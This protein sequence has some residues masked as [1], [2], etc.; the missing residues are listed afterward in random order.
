V[1]K[2]TRRHHHSKHQYSWQIN[3]INREE[4]SNEIASKKVAAHTLSTLTKRNWKNTTR[5]AGRRNG[6]SVFRFLQAEPKTPFIHY[7]DSSD[8]ITGFTGEGIA[9]I[10]LTDAILKNKVDEADAWDQEAQGEEED[11]IAFSLKI[12]EDEEEEETEEEKKE[13]HKRF[14]SMRK[15][16]YNMKAALQKKEEDDE[17][18]KE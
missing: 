11:G 15:G 18:D 3:Q 14:E 10:E 9:P 2:K 16:H 12:V 13:K 4:F 1:E 6:S 5:H 8:Q 7:N 17:E